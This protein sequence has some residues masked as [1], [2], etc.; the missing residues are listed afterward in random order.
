MLSWVKEIWEFLHKAAKDTLDF[1]A[2]G[3]AGKRL[4]CE[5]DEK[6]FRGESTAVSQTIIS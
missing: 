1:N 3:E 5:K 4:M 2:L 6:C